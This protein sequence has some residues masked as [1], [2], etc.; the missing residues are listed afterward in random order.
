[1][2]GAREFLIHYF[3]QVYDPAKAHQYYEEHKKLKGRS[4]SDQESQSKSRSGSSSATAPKVAAPQKTAAQR[5]AE[6]A[7]ATAA[8]KARLEQLRKL[9]IELVAEAKKRS[10]VD[11]SD[12]SPKPSAAVEKL[13]PGEK[14]EKAEQSH[15]YYEKTKGTLPSQE[16]DHVLRTK[17]KAIEKKIA[18][19]RAKL[20]AMAETTTP[21]PSGPDST[22]SKEGDSQNGS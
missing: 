3:D 15:D 7:A 9:L 20:A 11:P 13:T 16:T 22:R 12:A 1:M 2:K 17:I 19:M 4:S 8:L 21:S 14:A 10:G 6:I 5:Q 18:E